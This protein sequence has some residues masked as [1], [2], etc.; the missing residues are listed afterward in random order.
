MAEQIQTISGEK[1]CVLTGVTD[2]RHRQI[3]KLGYFPPPIKGQY[4]LTATLQ[5][6]FKYYRELGE[7]KKNKR[8][9]ID[10]EKHRKLKLENDETAGLL[11][12]TQD[13]ANQI[14]PKLMKFRDN[15]YAT[16]ENEAPRCMSG[17]GVA[18]ARIIGRRM[19]SDLLTELQRIFK[20]VQ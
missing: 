7:Y 17:I 14:A 3:A 6:M 1:L 10:D 16:M 18:E 12:N 11:T 2:R 15:V 13:L 8:E 20:T 9:A 4:Q 19:A 5:G